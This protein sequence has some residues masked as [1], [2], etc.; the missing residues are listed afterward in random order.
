LVRPN[1]AARGHEHIADP[2]HAD[3]ICDRLIHNAHKLA[4]KDH[5]NAS[6][7]SQ[8]PTSKQSITV[9]IAPAIAIDRFGDRDAPVR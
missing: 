5:R 3:A 8:K 7:R 6:P 1:G 2:T 4:L 9:P